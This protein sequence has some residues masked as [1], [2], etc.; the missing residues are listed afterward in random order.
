MYQISFLRNKNNINEVEE[1]IRFL[2]NKTDKESK[3]KYTK[4]SAYIEY[5]AKEG[6]KIGM[7]Y[8]KNIS[9]DLW[10]LRPLKDRIFFGTV[11]DNRFIILSRFVKSSK[12]TPKKEI[13]Y[14]NKLLKKYKEVIKN[15]TQVK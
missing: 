4:I 8:V 9:N 10:E 5:L 13:I 14:A 2:R 12:K 11:E 15:G 7:P 6:L 3:I 1:Y